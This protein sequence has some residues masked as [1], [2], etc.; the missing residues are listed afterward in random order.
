MENAMKKNESIRTKL[1]ANTMVLI[2]VIFALLT[3]VI[4]V[5]NVISVNQNVEKSKKNIRASL[6]AKGRTLAK[7]NSLAMSGMAAENG[8]T[9]IQHLV[10]STVADD[11]DLS[12][13]IYMT[14]D[15][16]P[17]VNASA[18]DPKGIPGSPA[19]LDD[20]ISRWASSLTDL[21]SKEFSGPLGTG[22]E[23]AAPVVSENEIL[24]FIRY[25]MST[26]SMEGA[27]REVQLAGRWALHTMMLIIL[28]IAVISLAIGFVMIRKFAA[29]ITRPIGSLVN[30]SKIISEGNYDIAVKPESNDEI[31]D[32]AAH[33]EC[34]RATIKRY[35]DHLQDLIDEK[36]QQVNDILNN[37]DQG[38][39]TINLDGTVNQEYSARANTILNVDDVAGCTLR[40]LLRLNS[41]Q[42]KAFNTWLELVRKKHS[43][44]RWSKL[45]KL[46]PVQE[47]E[48][49]VVSELSDVEYVSI[50]YEKIYD[51]KGDLAKIM[52]LAADETEKRVRARLMATER[53][54]HENDVKAIL[55]I[56]NTP[57]E[58]IAE[59]NEDTMAR[60]REL[61]V[62]AA[63]HLEGV[64][65][66]RE[67]FPGSKPYVITKE[68]IDRMYRDFHTI[69]GNSGSY[70]F[71]LLAL[72]AH[73]AEDYV[74]KLREPVEDRRDRIL[75]EINTRIDKMEASLEDIH[76]KIRLIYGKEEEI[77]VRIPETRVNAIV[78][79]S[80]SVS[81]AIADD[82]VTKLADECAM[83]SWKPLKTHFRKYQKL[84]VKTARKLQKNIIFVV[85]DENVL[86]PGDLVAGLDDVLLHLVRNAVDHG[87]ES[88]DVRDELGKGV[89]RLLVNVET[90]GTVRKITLADDGRGIDFDRIVER[91]VA[92][93]VITREES[94]QLSE[95][96]KIGLLFRGGVSTAEEISE[97][98]GRGIG[99]QVVKE[100]VAA[101]GGEL[102]IE[103]S[104][105]KG[106]A[107]IVTVPVDRGG[108]LNGAT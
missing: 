73:E 12:Y 78:E 40:E 35:T 51:K 59:F 25:G 27:I 49:P 87:I 6:M 13:G 18:V 58:E 84:A 74:E 94:G 45:I 72:S 26:K 43:Q 68:H 5:A 11:D 22:I 53:I 37:I 7:N 52:I 99:M 103:S 85:N 61:R 100:K 36:M 4:T 79:L 15:R 46:A 41:N 31:G 17:W 83:L 14:V 90:V 92:M 54:R 30:S 104:S 105:G 93:N 96:E 10:A 67:N 64:R 1:V 42:E 24:G 88:P 29:R 98:S 3:S 95:R 107:F 50:S 19:P 76:Q 102:S 33:F 39:F 70:G 62:E 69:K 81:E 75:Y 2:V 108:T 66:Q 20:S 82:R 32:L 106:T 63:T 28:S 80:R 91:A 89:G 86:Y 23:F 55:S 16:V 97:I 47:I 77:T 21:S 65:R 8:F 38:L 56:A 101:I 71:E 57:A 9:S 60:L 34:M 44:H 48:L